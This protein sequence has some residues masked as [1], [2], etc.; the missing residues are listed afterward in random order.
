M[1][2]KEDT[3]GRLA[4]RRYEERHFEERRAKNKAWGTTVP[5]AYADEIDK[6][7][8]KHGLTKVAL[9]EAGYEV[10][11]EKVKG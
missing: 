6:F 7:L 8:S 11:K 5:R 9:I 1:A 2:R 4:R 3:P 10:L